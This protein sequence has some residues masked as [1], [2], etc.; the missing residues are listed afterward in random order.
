MQQILTII[1]PVFG[2][3]AIGFALGRTPLMTAE[4]VKGLTNFVFYA[5]IPALLFRSMARTTLP[6]ADDLVLVVTYF[7]TL[8]A[9]FL[10]S[11]AIARFVFRLN[12]A[13]QGLF[14][15]GAIFGNTVLAGIPIVYAAFGEP[16]LVPLLLII[17][18]HPTLIFPLVTLIIEASLGR[19]GGAWRTIRATARSLV[20]NPVIVA[21]LAGI[22]WNIMGLVIPGGIDSFLK[23]L[24]GAAAPAALFALGA[25]LTRFK[26]ASGLAENA[27][28]SIIKLAVLPTVIWISL[29]MLTDLPRL[30]IAVAVVTAALPTGANVFLLAQRYNIYV[31]R[32]STVV[33]ASTAASAVTL[34]LVLIWL[35]ASSG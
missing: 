33:L 24:G 26:L 1:G 2:L 16:G 25:T 10:L 9:V 21:L 30:W 14:A 28:M 23:L 15:M 12:L 11:M 29:T 13:D 22:G 19:G 31:A 5:A 6:A 8:G 7:G 20:T 34:S 18:F 27:T 32:T 35:G 17:V 4:G 3:I